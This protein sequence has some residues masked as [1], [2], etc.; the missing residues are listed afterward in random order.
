MQARRRPI[1]LIC[2]PFVVLEIGSQ[3]AAGLN[4]ENQ[5][6]SVSLDLLHN[7]DT[8]DTSNIIPKPASNTGYRPHDASILKSTF[9]RHYA[10]CR[11][12]IEALY[13][14]HSLTPPCINFDLSLKRGKVY[15]MYPSNGKLASVVTISE[16]CVDSVTLN[17]R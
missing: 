9:V 6:L 10:V 5:R 14:T 16:L 1:E 11:V 15:K 2:V 17:G 3:Y 8:L 13:R 7:V 12:C 4:Q